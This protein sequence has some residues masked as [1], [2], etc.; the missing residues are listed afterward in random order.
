[1]HKWDGTNF[2][3]LGSGLLDG[4]NGPV[5]AL[6]VSGSNLYT[7]GDF[8][9]AGGSGANSI[10]KWDGSSW[11]T[12]G[13]GMNGYV[14]ALAVSGSNLYAG[15]N[16]TTAGGNAANRIGKWDGSSWSALGS[17]VDGNVISLAV[18]GSDLYAGGI[19][20]N[21]GGKISRSI[22]RA[23]I[24]FNPD[25]IALQA[26]VPGVHTNTLTFAGVP[27]YPYIVEYS[28]NLADGSWFFLSTNA[29]ATNGIGTFIDSTA[30]DP[31]RFYRVGY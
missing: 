4:P 28:T 19:F 10:A 18:S 15:G 6:A 5:Y 24:D 26:D 16:F 25:N 8:T 22:A 30:N 14:Q 17:G 2:S 3:A 7:G 31:Q 12:L 27:D 23:R 11:S 20:T 13:S 21:A 9:T 29:P 1:M